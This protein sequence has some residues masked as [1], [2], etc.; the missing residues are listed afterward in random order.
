MNSSI[1]IR[2]NLTNSMIQTAKEALGQAKSLYE[3]IIIDIDKKQSNRIYNYS[4][5]LTKAYP[6]ALSGFGNFY[7][8]KGNAI[9][10]V[11]L[12]L[13]VIPSEDNTILIISC[14]IRYKRNVEEYMEFN[15]QNDLFILCMIEQWMLYG[16]DYW[17][18]K[19]SIW[20]GIEKV[21]QNLILSEIFNLK[22]DINSPAP[23]S[24]FN[25]LKSR[26]IKQVES[27][28]GI[29]ELPIP[30]QLVIQRE[31]EK[32]NNTE[33]SDKKSIVDMLENFIN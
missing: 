30:I 17:F 15:L 31:K 12:I 29:N 33:T 2:I 32:I 27:E 19:P 21:K 9:D 28:I 7:V 25:E 5:K 10:Y 8:K 23:V 3:K 20:K 24:I 14:P 22:N 11:P 4:V 1:D 16:S 18:I 26:I 13:N 6:V